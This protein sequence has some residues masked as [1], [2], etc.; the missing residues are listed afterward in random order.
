MYAHTKRDM[1]TERHLN[2]RSS[3]STGVRP[4]SVRYVC[5]FIQ[6]TKDSV[7]LLSRPR[8]HINLLF[9]TTSA[10]AQLQGN[11]FIGH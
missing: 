7:N 6:T 1:V 2:L 11:P 5:V 9:L 3:P 4:V 10:D 8:S